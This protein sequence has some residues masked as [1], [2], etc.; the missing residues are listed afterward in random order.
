MEE[1]YLF[2]TKVSLQSILRGIQIYINIRASTRVHTM[3]EAT[4]RCPNILA[5]VR[6]CSLIHDHAYVCTSLFRMTNSDSMFYERNS[7]PLTDRS[8]EC[9]RNWRILAYS[10][11]SALR[12]ST[13]NLH[14]TSVVMI[15][16][17]FPIKKYIKKHTRASNILMKI[18]ATYIQ[19]YA[20]SKSNVF[21][22]P[23]PKRCELMPLIC[24]LT[25]HNWERN[26]R[27]PTHE[28]LGIITYFFVSF[29]VNL[30]KRLDE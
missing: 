23:G 12:G 28:R 4:P 2:S 17:T 11:I 14:H 1:N 22:D 18:I 21:V 26:V 6:T 24:T 30:T 19:V 15:R 5:T 25:R 8:R 13:G 29:C 9:K 27:A 20:G 7:L 10:G 16:G 3:S